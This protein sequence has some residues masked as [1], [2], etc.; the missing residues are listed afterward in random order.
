MRLLRLALA[1]L[2][3]ACG[4]SPTIEQKCLEGQHQGPA[5][6]CVPLMDA[7]VLPA[8]AGFGNDRVFFVQS[9]TQFGRHLIGTDTVHRIIVSGPP[10]GAVIRVR[11]LDAERGGYFLEGATL[12]ED[13][14]VPP[15]RNAGFNVRFTPD[16]EGE[17]L[18]TIVI[19]T[20]RSG[21]EMTQTLQGFGSAQALRCEPLLLGSVRVGTCGSALFS[22]QNDVT[23][24]LTLDSADVVPAVEG[25]SPL[26]AGHQPLFPGQ[27]FQ[28]GVQFC[29]VRP[30][31]VQSTL[32]LAGSAGP[33]RLTPVQVPIT[34]SADPAPECELQMM[35]T[36]PLPTA[37]IGSTTDLLVRVDNTGTNECTFSGAR[38][39][40]RDATNFQLQS[41]NPVAIGAGSSVELSIRFS[42]SRTGPHDARLIVPTVNGD[43]LASLTAM[44]TIASGS[45]LVSTQTSTSFAPP[46]G[47]PIPWNDLDDGW[48]F[49]QLPF[50]FSYLG[51]DL[52]E[53]SVNTNGYLSFDHWIGT[54]PRVEVFPNPSPPNGVIAWWWDD[55]SYRLAP[56]G[57]AEFTV[58]GS[59]PRRVAHFVFLDVPSLGNGRETVSG[60]VRLYEEDGAVEIQYGPAIP[61]LGRFN[62]ALGWESLDGTTGSTLLACSPHCSGPDFPASTTIRL[63][64]TR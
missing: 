50:A 21:C 53:V 47:T 32:T 55:L 29:P 25:L 23:D 64:P 46:P 26:L 51:T 58:T 31:L 27:I 37:V 33:R 56:G 13:I 17:F 8:D 36:T 28:T 3:A 38:I 43:A 1:A 40:G 45:F 30:G 54:I 15:G 9:D 24:S 5:G 2:L 7:G 35:Q 4:A 39:E 60:W 10:D 19:D 49:V 11:Q 52:S 12:G 57:R 14:L 16:A 18:A 22:C 61:S 44:G 62:A 34:G 63:T 48:A 59:I 6:L 41:S 42:P 20:C